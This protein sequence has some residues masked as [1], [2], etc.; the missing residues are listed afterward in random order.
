MPSH[1]VGLH[2][3]LRHVL[4]SHRLLSRSARASAGHWE[5]LSLSEIFQVELGGVTS[6]KGSFVVDSRPLEGPYI[7]EPRSVL[8]LQCAEEHSDVFNKSLVE[9]K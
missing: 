1:P 3:Q 4:V 2:L 6:R 8:F 5:D 7:P 9:F